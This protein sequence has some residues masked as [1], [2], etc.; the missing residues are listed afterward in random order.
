MEESL[1]GNFCSVEGE[2]A[3]ES[4]MSSYFAMDTA[5]EGARWNGRNAS[6]MVVAA[7]KLGPAALGNIWL[8][9]LCKAVI[10]CTSAFDTYLTIKYVDSLTTYEQNPVGRWLMGLDGGPVA[11][12]Q[13]I[14]AFVTAKFLGTIIVLLTIQGLALWRLTLAGLVAFAVAIFQLLLTAHLLFS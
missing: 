5:A 8:L 1:N 9:W 3:K 13:Q 2:L 14:A 4:R 7:R 10:A 11:D 12:T 6:T